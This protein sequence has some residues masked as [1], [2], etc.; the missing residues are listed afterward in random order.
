MTGIVPERRQFNGTTI[1]DCKEKRC[2]KNGSNNEACTP[3]KK[4]RKS[5]EKIASRNRETGSQKNYF[6]NKTG[7]ETGKTSGKKRNKTSGKER[8]S[9][10]CR[11]LPLPALRVY[12]LAPP[13]RTAQRH[14][15][16]NGI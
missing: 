3:C 9:R 5:D 14:T 16:R 11:A 12:L 13:R 1:T 6:R 8:K 7:K 4:E 10:I 2:E 15:G